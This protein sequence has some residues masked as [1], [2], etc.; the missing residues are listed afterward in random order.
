MADIGDVVMLHDRDTRFSKKDAVRPYM[1]IGQA[2]SSTLLCPR[3]ALRSGGV[4]TPARVLPV[5]TVVS[6]SRHG[7]MRS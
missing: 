2:G 4:F 6:R 7:G 1:V 3:S 5:E